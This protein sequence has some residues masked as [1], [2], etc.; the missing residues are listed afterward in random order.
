M[1]H[2]RNGK[3]KTD[4]DEWA[5][6][7]SLFKK[8]DDEFHF[9]LDAAANLLNAKTTPFFDKEG[10]ALKQS[11]GR[12]S[13]FLNPP[14]SQGNIDRFMQKAY[15]EGNKRA[16]REYVVC[17]IPVASDTKWW[18]NYVMKAKEIRFIKGRVKF[19][20]FDELGHQI[21]NSP[22]FSS[23]VAIFSSWHEEYWNQ[24]YHKIDGVTVIYPII[25]RTIIQ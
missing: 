12:R 8:L 24:P 5:T 3:Y 19:V 2:K 25:G 15:E 11:W 1:S 21:K 13:V 23:C 4:K 9:S 7:R 16:D 10:D 20:G 17:L 18:H 6:P 22:T 14:Y